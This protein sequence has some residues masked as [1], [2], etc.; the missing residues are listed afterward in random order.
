MPQPLPTYRFGPYEL[1][2]QSRELFKL[3]TKLRLRPQSYQVLQ[4]LVEYAGDAVNRE[5][6][7]RALW[8]DATVVDFEL[9]V[10]TCIKELRGVLSDSATEPRYIQTL[11]KV[12]YRMIRAVSVEEVF[13]PEE[14]TVGASNASPDDPSQRPVHL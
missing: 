12:G 1:R 9:G 13:A 11:P 4:L 2:T 5:Q 3:G 7:H 10:N 6:L 8:P 14:A